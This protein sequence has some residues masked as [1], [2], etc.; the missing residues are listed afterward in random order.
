M[1]NENENLENEPEVRKLTLEVDVQERSSCERHV[2]VTVSE[3]DVNYYVDREVNEIQENQSIP[4]FRAGKAPRKVV[5]KRYRKEIRERAK[6]ALLIDSL[7]QANDDQNMTPISEP[8]FKYD[9]IVLPESGA[10]IYEYDVEVRPT[11]DIPN[12][13]GLKLERPTRD[14]TPEDV[15]AAIKRI[16]ASYGSLEPKGDDEPAELGDYIHTKLSFEVDGGV[17]R[18]A[19]NE[20]IRIRPTLSFHD[21]AIKDFDK[22]M[23]GV[24]AGDVRKTT[25][26]LSDDAADE[27]LRGKEIDAIFEIMEVD[28]AIIPEINEEFLARMGGFATLGDFRDAVQETM[29]RQ[30]EHEQQ[31]TARRQISAVLTKDANWELPHT[32]LRRQQYRELSRQIYELQRSG[33]S[34]DIIKKHMNYL[35]QNSMQATAQALKEHFIFEAIAESENIEATD[36]DYEFEIMLI[37]SQTGETP[38]R[39]R[40]RIEKSGNMDVLRN[41]IIE[42]KVVNM[43]MDEAEFTDVPYEMDALAD[44]SEEAVD[45]A[46]GA[47][48]EDI[49]EVTEEEAKEAAREAAEKNA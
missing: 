17:L 10:F 8:D 12:W 38:R 36:S 18:Q 39:V 24:K 16:Q 29:Q 1:A 43:I 3:D 21:C 27:S 9:A 7:Q 5:A 28:R 6:N 2:K 33:F 48:E 31:Q 35:R 45:R 41:Q 15:D 23:V 13:K 4:G 11:F 42:R 20:T 14:F 19:E 25:V 32:L 46:V 22:L 37:A 44:E 49:P 47:K 40:S 34:D 26:T 30:M